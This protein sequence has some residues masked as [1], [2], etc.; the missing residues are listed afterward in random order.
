[1]GARLSPLGFVHFVTHSGS[2]LP[3]IPTGALF[4]LR[5]K[6]RDHREAICLAPPAAEKIVPRWFL[7]A[8]G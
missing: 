7:K 1:M 4:F 2:V 6:K 8:P 3:V 5:A